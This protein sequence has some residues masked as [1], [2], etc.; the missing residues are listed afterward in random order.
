MFNSTTDVYSIK[1]EAVQFSKN[2][3]PEEKRVE[4][5]FVTQMIY[6]ML[7]S[8]S[9]I[10]RNIA[11]ALNE[12]IHMKNTIERLSRNLGCELSPNIKQNYTN[13]M[14]QSLGKQPV[15]LVDDTD[16]IK[17]H[18]KAFE[19]LGKVRDGSSEGN[20][21]EKGYLVTELVGITANKKQ[22][23][24]LF[25]HLHSSKEKGYK[26]TNEVL[27]QGLNQVIC[28]LPGKATFVFDRGYDMNALFDFM[29]KKEQDFIIRLTEKRKLLWKGK[30]FK[31]SVLRDSRKGKIK[32]KLTFRK[33]GKEKRETV[34]ISH[35]NIK[36]TASKKTVNL[37]L[38][39][40]LGETPMM[41]ATNKTIRRKEDVIQIV[42]TYMSR[43]RIEEYFRFKKQHFG[44]ENFRV[45][46]LQSINNLNQLLTYV[47]GLLGLLAEKIDKR[48]MTRR[49]I[50][51]AKALRKDIQFY[52]YQLAEGVLATLAH[53][54]T[55]VQDWFQIRGRTSH[56]LKLIFA[57]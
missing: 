36:I 56:Q 44:F 8:G 46:S 5:K 24:S 21:I 14:L 48:E 32:T 4:S 2:L 12:S 49:L 39:Y 34:Y 28:Q 37:V 41:L 6:G 51:N 10:L 15:I 50:H 40:G 19:S 55:G 53:A 23:V 54:K 11:A 26:S 38:V 3:V 25:S 20:K 27:F 7:K 22:P 31:S 43:W 45:R 13:Q 16:V 52:Y 9:I 57:G 30:W 33:D 1:R 18:G 29:Y 42:R 35:L 47:I 17:P